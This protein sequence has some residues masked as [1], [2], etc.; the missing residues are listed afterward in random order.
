[1]TCR[2]PVFDVTIAP[3]ETKL[4]ANVH[5]GARTMAFAGDAAWFL[6]CLL[7]K[8]ISENDPAFARGRELLKGTGL[9]APASS[10]ANLRDLWEINAV[11]VAFADDQGAEQ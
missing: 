7:T 6:F 1:M 2:P 3:R 8:R 5:G 10:E 4:F 9:L 11:H